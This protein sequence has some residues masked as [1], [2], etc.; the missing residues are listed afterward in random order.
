M[1][2]K[3]KVK[4]SD[5]PNF[6]EEAV[7]LAIK[8]AQWE[9]DFQKEDFHLVSNEE[10]F[11]KSV[12]EIDKE[13]EDIY[14][15]QINILEEAVPLFKG[16]KFWYEITRT[17]DKDIFK[18]DYLFSWSQNCKV[19]SIEEIDLSMFLRMNLEIF[20][21]IYSNAGHLDGEYE[22]LVE[23]LFKESSW[24]DEIDIKLED[25]FELINNTDYSADKKLEVLKIYIETERIYKDFQEKLGTCEE[26]VKRH[27][28]LVE[29]RFNRAV[30]YYKERED[31]DDIFEMSK[32]TSLKEYY[33][34]EVIV[35]FNCVK[36]NGGA[37][38]VTTGTELNTKLTLGILLMELKAYS[39]SF[40]DSR[41]KLIEK[42]KAIGDDIRFEIICH[43]SKRPYYVK[44]LAEKMDLSS[45]SISHHLSILF[46]ADF[47]EP[48]VHDRKTYYSLKENALRELGEGLIRFEKVIG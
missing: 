19:S 33:S 32:I 18:S 12:E 39:L 30:D 34:D 3:Y 36:Y 43:L 14:N 6:F 23:N 22:S 29:P 27:Y 20:E 42:C 26:I 46:H 17:E 44:E 28:H 5:K 16:D 11:K 37:L 48:K 13:F 41:E 7:Q 35:R 9:G 25:I 45:A 10:G 4:L 31:Y 8:A 15:F 21:D 38:R 40:E 47:I 24:Q 1:N 2:N